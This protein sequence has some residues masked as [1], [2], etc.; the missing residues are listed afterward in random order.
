MS[1]LLTYTMKYGQT[2]AA[3]PGPMLAAFLDPVEELIART[4]RRTARNWSQRSAGMVGSAADRGGADLTTI[5]GPIPSRNNRRRSE[6]FLPSGPQPLHCSNDQSIDNASA[7]GSAVIRRGTLP[8]RTLLAVALDRLQA[9]SSGLDL[10]CVGG[11]CPRWRRE[12]PHAD[13]RET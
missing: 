9:R 2:T 6:R 12:D 1:P 11:P 10:G 7:E 8:F 13:R 5:A 3:M 4:R